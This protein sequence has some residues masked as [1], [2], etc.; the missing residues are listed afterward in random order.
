MNKAKLPARALVVAG[1]TS[2]ILGL[3]GIAYNSVSLSLDYSSIPHD[4]KN[5]A[6]LGHFH[7]AFYAM[8][9]ICLAFYTGLIVVGIQ[10]MRKRSR[11]AFG[12]LG[13]I[14]LEVLYS[15]AEG[16]LWMSSEYGPSVAAATGVSGGG[17]SFQA[18]VLFPIWGPWVALWA[19]RKLVIQLADDCAY[20]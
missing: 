3:L 16:A 7:T 19:H 4:M 2:L 5:E 11:W 13:I 18:F 20:Q 9:G 17:L 12:L 10:L 1:A 14:V 6:E 8:S 15:L